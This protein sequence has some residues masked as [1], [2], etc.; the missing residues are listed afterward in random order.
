MRHSAVYACVRLLAE[1]V[2][3]LPLHVYRRTA[4]GKELATDHPLYRVLHDSPNDEMTSFQFREVMQAHLALW[5]NAYAQIQ[6]DG[7]GRIQLWPIQPQYVQPERNNAGQIVYKVYQYQTTGT[8]RYLSYDE[9]LHIPGLSFNGIVGLSPIGLAREAIGLG[10]AAEKFGARF[11]GSGT[12]FGTVLT[13]PNSLSD[14]ALAHLRRSFEKRAKGLDNSHSMLILEEGLDIKNV[15]IPPED[16]Q[17]I[18]TRKFQVNDIARIFRI[19]PHMIGDL[20]RATFSNIEQQSIEFVQHTIR[21]WLVRWEQQINKKLLGGDYFAEFNVDGL[22][23]GDIKSRYEA[24]A[25]ARQ[26]GWMSA[27]DIR[28]LENMDPLPGRVGDTY[29][30]PLNMQDAAQPE[31]APEGRAEIRAKEERAMRSAETRERLTESY[32]PLFQS[33][34]DKFIQRE[35]ADVLQQYEKN[36]DSFLNW[37]DGYYQG[38]RDELK[39]AISGVL[40]GLSKGIRAAILA[41]LGNDSPADELPRELEL[42][43]L[44]YADSFAARHVSVSANEIRSTLKADGQP[45]D[46]LS[47]LMETWNKERAKEAA[48][49]EARK[50]GNAV[51]RAVYLSEG[52]TKIRWVARGSKNC[53]YCTRMNGKTVS[54][55]EPFFRK[56][57]EYHPEG[58]ERPMQMK[59]D[60]KHPPIHRGCDCT[61]IA[62][63]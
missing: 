16:S 44:A 26:N 21:P 19:P 30:V 41:E 56:G 20:E 14:E 2:A 51:S 61:I 38:F 62:D 58:A 1:T 59:K 31:P 32:I 29:L 11:F 49:D 36:P 10:L 5:G 47:A 9:M 3:S 52:V 46:N 23:R 43:L 25:I 28:R 22:L 48:A 34:L 57:D 7:S 18:E 37:L 63:I 39:G 60:L 6:R 50:A 15:A 8:F 24:Y 55:G 53:P 13:H 54:I 40:Q 42:F 12:N 45:A 4:T 27:N 35:S 33:T 17:F